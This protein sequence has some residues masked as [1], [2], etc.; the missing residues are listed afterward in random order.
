[1]LL[2]KCGLYKLVA[3]TKWMVCLDYVDCDTSITLEVFENAEDGYKR[4]E[5]VKV[6]TEGKEKIHLDTFIRKIEDFKVKN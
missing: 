4:F 5:E 1:M 6:I 3:R 2:A